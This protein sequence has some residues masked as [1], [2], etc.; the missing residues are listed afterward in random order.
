MTLT[1]TTISTSGGGLAPSV[2]QITGFQHAVLSAGTGDFTLDASAFTLGGVVLL[3]GTGNDT[4]IGTSGPDTLVAGAG[5]DS[6][7]GGGGNDI[8][9]FNSGSSGSQTVVEKPGTG[10][11]GLD[12]S[13]APAGISINLSQ[14]GP[15]TVIP[16]TL[17]L[18][19]ADPL[20]IDNVLGSSYNDTIIGN[21]NDNTLIGAGGDD[22]IAGLGGND[23]LE[24]AVTRTVYLDFDTYEL[25]GQHDYSQ[26]ERDAI[27]AQITADYSA[28]SYVFTQTRP[29]S[30]A[31]TTISF[32]DPELVGLEGGVSTGIDWRDLDISGS[33]TL[34]AYGLQVVAPD[35]ASVN[36]NDLLGGPGE[37][38]ATSADFIGLSATIAAHELGHLSGLEH[39]D[40]YGPIGSGIYS[41]VNPDLYNPPYPG[42]SNADETV[43]HIMASGA[44]VNATLEDAINDPFFGER[45]AIKL[46][47]GENGTP[48]NEETTPHYSMSD[49]QAITLQ[50]LVVPDTDLEGVNADQTFN[51]TAADIVGDLGLDSSGQSNT[52]YYSFTAQAGTL[53]NLQVMSAVLINPPQGAF[54]TT[55]TVYDSS[56]KVIAYND[57]SFQDTDSTIIDL[58]LPTTGIYYV[59]VTSSSKPGEPTDQTGNYELFMYTFALGSD[60]SA[61]DSLY[62][63]SGDDT[64]IAG[65]ADDTIAAEP[66]D[67]IVYGSGTATMLESA[68]YL[69]VSAGQN[70]TVNEGTCVTLTGSFLDPDDANLHTYDWHVVASSGQQI[71]DGTGLTYQFV[72]GNAGTYTLTFTVKDQNGGSASAEVAITSLD[73][74]PV[75]IAPTL[76]QTV[77][78]GQNESINL[79]DLATTGVGPFVDTIQWGDGQS[80]I[81]DPTG[82]GALAFNHTYATPGPYTIIETVS[83]FAGGSTSVTFSINVTQVVAPATDLAVSPDTGISSSDGITDTGA[84][85]LTGELALS[86]VTVDVFD[87]STNTD[88]GDATVTGTSFSLAM[89]LAQGSHVL[90]VQTALDGSDADAFFTVLVD[91]TPPT[92]HVVNSLGTSQASDSFPVTVAFSDPAG[93]GTAP[94]SGVSSVG[95]WVSV[96]NGAFSLYQTTNIA[97][98][99]SGTVTFTFVGQDRNTYAFHSIA[100]D[101]A[102]NT[103]SKNSN[104]IEASTSVPD[105]KPPVTHVLASSPA[106]S[107]SPFPSSNFGSLTPSSYSSGVFT[108]NWAGADPDQNSGSPKGSIAVVDLYVEIDGSTTPTLIGQLYPAH[109]NGN[110]VYSGSLSYDAVADGVSH[111]YRFFSVGIDDEQKAQPMPSTPDVTFSNVSY[112]APLAVENLAVEK[113]IAE[114]SFIEYLDVDFNQTAS[115]STALQSLATAL[116]TPGTADEQYVQ[117]LWYGEGTP[118]AGL[119]RGTVN[120]FGPGTTATVTLSGNDL[121]INFGANGITS[122]LNETGVTGTGKPTTNFGDGWYALGIDTT[123]GNGPVFWE[124]FFRLFGSATGDT[125]VSGPYTASG[126][127]AYVVYNAEGETGTLLNADVDGSGAV[128]SKDLTYTAGARGDTVGAAPQGSYPAFQLFGGSSAAVPVNATVVTQSEVQSLLPAA[129]DAWQVAGLDAN[130]VRKL[131]SVPIEVANLGTTILGLEAGGVITINQTAAGYNW[132]VGTSS[133][134]SQPF[135]IASPTGESL[136]APGSPAI[137]DVDLLTVLEH[138]LGHVLGL[139]DNDQ[140]GDLLDITLGLGVSRAP[141]SADVVAIGSG[142]S[143]SI[144][145]QAIDAAVP[146]LVAEIPTISGDPLAVAVKASVPLAPTI[147]TNRDRRPR[148]G[149]SRERWWTRLWHRS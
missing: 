16:G 80:S 25:P 132:Y 7:V 35:A 63:G 21:A 112:A 141:T 87:T 117:L 39:G 68:P 26:A 102:G 12:F 147:G 94:A 133:G 51:V 137:N 129:I 66:Q 46:S 145:S 19:L 73:V 45:E 76:T 49:P 98:T 56:G 37:P 5:N 40:S 33:T 104:T 139:P 148:T 138:E 11:A 58:T 142:S 93:S 91:L 114:R 110:G 106:Y 57:D 140:A 22:L 135:V 122:L 92:S 53:I 85:T 108:L 131:A 136:A 4:L 14:S 86:A 62:A 44:S 134:S 2:S 83:E 43:D 74:P 109:A 130:D 127:D 116:K 13:Q 118:S 48:T 31:Y 78:P 144:T 6:L 9:T 38:A 17:S 36:V 52:D 115:T 59:E 54:D 121:A 101:A 72:P 71:A 77:A 103:E 90:R 70:E 81:Y 32:N 65:S 149:P 89:N 61:G 125:T 10:I 18:T 20:G 100:V 128:N 15:Q 47:Y 42:A 95:L 111:N 124:P 79:G 120:L 41:G 88:L 30:G 24:G 3:G 82:S 107:W 28:F 146:A 119:P 27:Q 50:P 113:G 8:F 29:Q 60:P 96:N 55:L 84:V 67:T 75:L 23:V 69:N 64:V 99:A 97:P 34:N 1:N 105:L 126:T 143:T 123:G